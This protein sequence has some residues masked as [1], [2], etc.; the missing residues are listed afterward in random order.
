[1]FLIMYAACHTDIRGNTLWLSN[2]F[3][4]FHFAFHISVLSLSSWIFHCTSELGN[5][6]EH[7]REG[8]FPGKDVCNQLMKWIQLAMYDG[9]PT[10][11]IPQKTLSKGK[12]S[13]HS[14][15]TIYSWLLSSWLQYSGIKN[16][17]MN[18][19]HEGET[20]KNRKFYI[21]PS[22]DCDQIT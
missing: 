16:S 6:V 22:C 4:P 9:T 11:Y 19:K 8:R 13:H 20:L 14:M 10:I 21:N 17:D 18:T 2:E 3:K 7:F 1:M 15:F 5:K 12:Q